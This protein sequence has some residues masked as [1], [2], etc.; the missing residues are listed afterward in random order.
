MVTREENA[1]IE[2]RI[3]SLAEFEE[4][5]KVKQALAAVSQR[6]RDNAA[7]Y[8]Q[9]LKQEAMKERDRCIAICAQFPDNRMAQHIAALIR[10]NQPSC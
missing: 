3:R 9:A 6:Y 5:L 10:G 8:A 4:R 2:G 1:E 7:H